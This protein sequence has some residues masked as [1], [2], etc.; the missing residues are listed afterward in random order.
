MIIGCPS[1]VMRRQHLF[2]RASPPKL[3]AVIYPNLA[4]MILMWPF[5]IIV[6]MVPVRCISRS[7]RLK[8]DF[9]DE[10]LKIFLSKTRK[11]RGLIFCL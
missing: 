1:C 4:G 7:H 11:D 8:I 10:N 6:Q 3:L 5:L 9:R 2:Q